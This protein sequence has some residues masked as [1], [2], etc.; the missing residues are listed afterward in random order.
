MEKT[1][2]IKVL[3]VAITI[4]LVIDVGGYMLI[5]G[6][7]FSD[8][9]YFTLIN[10]TT[11]GLHEVIPLSNYGRLFT[12][13]V[14]LSGLSVFFYL[15]AMIQEIV[16]DSRIRT[17]FG[18]RRMRKLSKLQDHVI[19]AGFG[20]MG[21]NVAEALQLEGKHFV[22]IEKDPERFADAESRGY[23]VFNEDATTDAN[24]LALNIRKASTF[25]SLL[26]SDAQN[27]FTVLSARELNPNLFII[28][29]SF[30]HGNI[31][32]LKKS[33]ANI[34]ISPYDLSSRRIVNTVIRP[35]VVNLIDLVTQSRDLSLTLEEMLID[36]DSIIRNKKI[37]ESGIKENSNAIV[38]AVKRG[39][40]LNFNPSPDFVLEIGDILILIG[41]KSKISEIK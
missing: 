20:I 16:V 30:E 24:L 14:V 36:E 25:I 9:L 5:E 10:I 35:N 32:K 15:N 11:L 8:S 1:F 7:N 41:D 21:E 37:R 38:V 6:A 12:G 27:M 3:L 31:N 22:V 26:N 40:D 4:I 19:I 17:I 13:F 28:S 33:G 39:E 2:K 18:R 34:I 29:R 23:M